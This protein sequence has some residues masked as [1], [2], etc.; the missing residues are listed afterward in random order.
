M[1]REYLGKDG[2]HERGVD[3]GGDTEDDD[4]D[5]GDDYD[6]YGGDGL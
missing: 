2:E 4:E 3:A 5:D 6:A 1:L